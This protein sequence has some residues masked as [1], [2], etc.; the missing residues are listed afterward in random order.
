[1]RVLD[2]RSRPLKNLR[3][4]VTDRCN[5]RC[6]YCMPEEKYAWL[7]KDELLRFEEISLLVDVFCSLGVNKVRLTG[8]EP[9]LRQNLRAL[10]SMIS[11]KQS[12]RIVAL[13][14]GLPSN[15]AALLNPTR[16]SPPSPLVC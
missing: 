3:I 13:I 9:L 12:R 4:S 15:V 8:G 2:A 7:P 14:R 5:L 16:S 6:Q 10:I 11:Q 1:M